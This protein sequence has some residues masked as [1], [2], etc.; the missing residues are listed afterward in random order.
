MSLHPSELSL[1][2]CAC[3][4]AVYTM[5]F[6]A[7][8]SGQS[9]ADADV[10]SLLAKI[11]AARGT[12]KPASLAVEGTFLITFEGVP[13]AGWVMSGNFRETFSGPNRARSWADLGEN[14]VM[15]QGI[16]DD[17]VWEIDP[18]TGARVY[19]GAEAQA[20]RRYLALQHGASPSELYDDITRAGSQELGGRPHTVLRM[21]ASDGKSDTWYVD[22]ETGLVSR[23]DVKMPSSEGAQLVWGFAEEIE[24]QVTFADWKEVGG[25]MYAHRRAVKMGPATFTFT[26]T[27]VETDVELDP[28]SFAPP[29]AVLKIKS[30][31]A[32]KWVAAGETYQ[33]VEREPQSVASIRVKCKP[34][35]MSAT[36]AEVLPEVCAHVN[37]SG[38]KMTGMPFSR[39]HEIGGE[40]DLEA[41]I[42]V[43]KPIAEKG[44]VKNSELPGGK[45]VMAWHIGP[46]E[47]LIDSHKSLRGYLDAH[48]LKS[49]GGPWEV[50]WTDPG[51][52]PDP[53][54]WRTQLF[55]PIDK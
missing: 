24:G 17:L 53:S 23:I 50:Y 12:T 6:C 34:E 4:A 26:C 36:L 48:Q 45:A 16:S 44:R 19:A 1:L 7:A 42:P 39:Y 21:S 33:V 15:E 8:A 30:K 11:D 32:P 10:K 49:S 54:K 55:M 46:Y 35:A 9:Q 14:G 29:E 27:K 40:I 28:A 38:A 22:S 13:S 52:V 5:V 3:A 41:G 18:A 20:V 37:A 31:P 25:V 47:K 2:Q 51:M 43:A